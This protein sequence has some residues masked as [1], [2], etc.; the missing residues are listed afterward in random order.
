MPFVNISIWTCL[1]YSTKNVYIAKY[2]ARLFLD[3]LDFILVNLNF[4]GFSLT[5]LKPGDSLKTQILEMI[6][7]QAM[8]VMNRLS[9]VVKCFSF[10]TNL[11][12]LCRYKH[13]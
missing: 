13:T 5:N 12:V 6:L 7:T 9:F 8:A 3:G 10:Q 4:V 11:S 1:C 2:I